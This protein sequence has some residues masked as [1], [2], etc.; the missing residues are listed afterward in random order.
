MVAA[1]Q[2]GPVVPS[3]SFTWVWAAV[4]R[5][6]IGVEDAQ[7]TS[8]RQSSWKRRSTDSV[9]ALLGEGGVLQQNSGHMT[10]PCPPSHMILGV[11]MSG[12]YRHSSHCGL[13]HC[14]S[15]PFVP[16]T[17]GFSI[18][19]PPEPG[20]L[21]HLSLQALLHCSQTRLSAL[22]HLFIWTNCFPLQD[23]KLS[24]ELASDSVGLYHHYQ[25]SW[26]RSMCPPMDFDR[27]SS[28]S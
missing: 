23:I 4:M 19:V 7:H 14:L 21:I 1:D 20:S 17:E 6:Q 11:I 3:T 15:D 8:A 24:D 10:Q 22:R 18:P 25:L 26:K 5:E 27:F 9:G 28:P 2:R 16:V 12:A 13:H